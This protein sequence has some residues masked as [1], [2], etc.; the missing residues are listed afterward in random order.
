[1]RHERVFKARLSLDFNTTLLQMRKA[2]LTRDLLR[3]AGGLLVISADHLSPSNPARHLRFHHISPA[4]VSSHHCFMFVAYIWMIICLCVAPA[5]ARAHHQ[6]FKRSFISKTLAHG[7]YRLKPRL[8][9][10]LT[11]VT[12]PQ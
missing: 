9:K 10:H 11:M 3:V 8:F 1:M 5:V 7:E 4:H 2:C 12:L 6:H